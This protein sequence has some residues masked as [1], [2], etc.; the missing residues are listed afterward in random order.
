MIH[1]IDR[2]YC[3]KRSIPTRFANDD[4]HVRAER[5]EGA[6]SGNNRWAGRL[7]RLNICP[8]VSAEPQLSNLLSE[9]A[10]KAVAIFGRQVRVRLNV[11][12]L[13]AGLG[14]RALTEIV[15]SVA[16]AGLRRCR[17][18]FSEPRSHLRGCPR[19]FI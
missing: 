6:C 18:C 19:G 1:A 10:N 12:K 13:N 3:C 2:P 5:V 11:L 4:D 9:A 15:D 8:R 17:S 14:A 16:C 7:D